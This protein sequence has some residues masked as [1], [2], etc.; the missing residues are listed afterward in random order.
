MHRIYSLART[1]RD[2]NLGENGWLRHEGYYLKSTLYKLISPLTIFKLMQNRLTFI[3]LSVDPNIKTRYELIKKLYYSFSHDFELAGITPKLEYSPDVSDAIEKRIKEPEKY[4]RQGLYTGRLDNAVDS[5][6]VESP[7]KAPHCMSFGE[8]ESLFEQQGS[9]TRKA[10]EAVRDAFVLFHPKTRPVLWR[11]LIT[12]SYLYL[13]L[14][15]SCTTKEADSLVDLQLIRDIPKKQREE[16]EWRSS[17][18]EASDGEV[19]VEPFEVAKKYFE[20]HLN[21]NLNWEK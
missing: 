19:L 9:N 7:E 4:W 11:V 12:Q 16:F 8:F 10:F 18:G 17:K 13:A 20:K 2:G 5:L 1:A 14:I 21:Q 6:I 3:D 15:R